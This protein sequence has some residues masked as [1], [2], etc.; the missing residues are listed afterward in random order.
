MVIVYLLQLYIIALIITTHLL[1]HNPVSV[2]PP[3]YDATT[4][5]HPG[6]TTTVHHHHNYST[7][8]HLITRR[9]EQRYT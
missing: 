2:S 3:I 6:F 9:H 5:T 7:I 8:Q 1:T 4:T